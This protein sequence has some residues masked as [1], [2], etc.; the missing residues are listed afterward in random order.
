ALIIG[1]GGLGS[2]VAM[3]LA[4]A[5]VGHLVISDFDHVDES[6]LQRQ[7]IHSQTTIGDSKA[8]S[9]ASRLAEINPATIVD[10]FDYELDGDELRQQV[11]AADVIIDCTDNF[12]SRFELNRMS[13]ASGTPLVSA[14]AIRWEA[15]MST[16]DPR[17][18]ES[19]C[20]Q[21]LYPDI[22]VEGA[23]CAGEGV[24]A[25]LVGIVG[26]IQAMETLKVLM[27]V[28]D[29]LV[30]QLLLLDGLSME[31]QSIQLARN[32]KCPACGPSVTA[33]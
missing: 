5:G 3:Y 21:C 29:T 13:I 2:P 30:G 18:E 10:A 33:T 15:Q 27:D 20:Y 26:S 28:G 16:Y 23:T 17:V 32:P 25:P 31:F 9:A 19:P 12:T 8:S 4:A 24:V 6:N 22:S 1:M 11:D 14:A 7:I